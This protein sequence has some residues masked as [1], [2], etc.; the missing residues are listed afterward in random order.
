MRRLALPLIMLA[1][2]LPG[3]A[4]EDDFDKKYEETDARLTAEMKRL[5][6]QLDAELKKEPGEQTR[7]K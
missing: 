3:C 5:D 7:R 4:R 1:L 6:K 2:M